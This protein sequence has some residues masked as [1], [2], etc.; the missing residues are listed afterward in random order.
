MLTW[1]GSANMADYYIEVKFLNL[2]ALPQEDGV[3]GRS[4]AMDTVSGSLTGSWADAIAAGT[5]TAGAVT[6][7]RMIITN[8]SGGVMLLANN[9]DADPGQYMVLLDGSQR[10]ISFDPIVAVQVKTG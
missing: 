9:N 6:P 10:E 2:P 3:N 7:K 4:Y 5:L 8:N 1:K